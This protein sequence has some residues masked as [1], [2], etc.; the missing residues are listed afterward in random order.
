MIIIG[1]L[2]L[3]SSVFCRLKGLRRL[4]NPNQGSALDPLGPSRQRRAVYKKAALRADA[5]DPL[6]L[7]D[8]EHWKNAATPSPPSVSHP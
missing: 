3:A 8:G 4:K 5:P 1:I 2:D 7:L 6:T